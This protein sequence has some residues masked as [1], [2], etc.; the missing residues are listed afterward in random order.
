[1]DRTSQPR[2]WLMR[3]AFLALALAIILFHLIPLD[4][5]PRRWAPPDLLIAFAMAWSL[6]R[7]DYVPALSI[8]AVML[9]ADLLFQRPP[10]LLAVL[11]VLGS[12]YL[13]NRNAGLREAGFLAEWAAVGSVFV[14]ITLLNRLILGLLA[15]QQA[16]LSLSLIQLL[17]TI[18]A[19]P[20]VVLVSHSAMGVRRPALREKA[21][22]GARA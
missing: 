17:L 20:A 13:K 14:A 3:A 1:M 9:T 21:I 10:G 15:V 8:A 4:T 5:Q 19:Y 18:A 7:P 22:L 11:V 2:L 12:E 6:R 16:Q